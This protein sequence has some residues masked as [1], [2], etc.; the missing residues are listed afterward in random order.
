M[1]VSLVAIIF[2]FPCNSSVSLGTATHM[3]GTDTTF[4]R[5]TFAI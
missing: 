2:L 5:L 3:E 4:F 1:L